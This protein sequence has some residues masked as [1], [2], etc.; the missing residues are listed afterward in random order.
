MVNFFFVFKSQVPNELITKNP[1]AMTITY[2]RE[3][4]QAFK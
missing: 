2:F 3:D 4:S 1:L